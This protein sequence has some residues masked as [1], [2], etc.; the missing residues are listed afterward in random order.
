MISEKSSDA[1]EESSVPAEE[2]KESSSQ[3]HSPM[4]TPPLLQ[5]SYHLGLVVSSGDRPLTYPVE[6][7]ITD[8]SLSLPSHIDTRSHVVLDEQN[9][10]LENTYYLM[11]LN[12]EFLNVG[13]E[14][15][16]W[17]S[18]MNV[19]MES[20]GVDTNPMAAD[21]D[22]HEV[23]SST[24]PS[25]SNSNNPPSGPPNH[26]P[27]PGPP[28]PPPPPSTNPGGSS[29]LTQSPPN[30][31]PDSSQ[32][33]GGNGNNS[34][35]TTPPVPSSNSTQQPDSSPETT[36]VNVKSGEETDGGKNEA[37]SSKSRELSRFALLISV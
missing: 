20:A 3:P 21:G 17:F 30:P 31:P 28:P 15:D 7:L 32:G 2:G 10:E 13:V 23:V 26:P 6:T 4:S 16:P 24:S 9:S 33:S 8:P 11:E 14:A 18:S 35:T 34:S 27:P 29:G 25:S 19:D 5:P 1:I 12:N 37:E 36:V 22:E